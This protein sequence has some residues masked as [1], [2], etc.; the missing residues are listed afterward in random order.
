M[1]ARGERLRAGREER[2]GEAGNG[3]RG[4]RQGCWKHANI[5]ILLLAQQKNLSREGTKTEHSI[6]PPKRQKRN[7]AEPNPS[8]QSSAD[9][10]G[11]MPSTRERA[12]EEGM[13][14]GSKG[15][16]LPLG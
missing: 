7:V 10:P 15:E 5:V 6:N 3:S 16:S 8:K 13:E 12:G 11:Q 9:T 2:G 1:V 4:G 14:E